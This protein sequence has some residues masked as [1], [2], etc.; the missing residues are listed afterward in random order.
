MSLDENEVRR[1]LRDISDQR[2][3]GS[4]CRQPNDWPPLYRHN[5]LTWPT[6]TLPAA[7]APIP[8]AAPVSGGPMTPAGYRVTAP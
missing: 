7:T 8:R 6:G 4:A 3:T 2:D 5:W 1:V